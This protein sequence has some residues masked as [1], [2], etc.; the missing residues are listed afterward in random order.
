MIRARRQFGL[1]VAMEWVRFEDRTFRVDDG[2]E[3]RGAGR[4]GDRD[5]GPA[6]GGGQEDD[7][8]VFRNLGV[9]PKY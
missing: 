5:L 3:N 8:F 9:S 6:R 7:A 4:N 1:V 2:D